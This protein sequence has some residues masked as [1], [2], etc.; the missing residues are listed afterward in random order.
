MLRHHAR[1]LIAA[2]KLDADWAVISACNA[3]GSHKPGAEPP[4]GFAGA[5]F[6]AGARAAHL[7]LAH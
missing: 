4:S 1:N 2:F 5:F 7:A 6:Y 3:A